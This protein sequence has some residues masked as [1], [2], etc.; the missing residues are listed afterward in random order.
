VFLPPVLRCP[1]LTLD[2]RRAP[3]RPL[4][5][6]HQEEKDDASRQERGRRLLHDVDGRDLDERG[7]EHHDRGQDAEVER[8]RLV[9]LRDLR[10]HGLAEADAGR[11][12]RAGDDREDRREGLRQEAPQEAPALR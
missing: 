10:Q 6:Q 5:E 11:D 4:E 12:P 1:T 7:R 8:G 9:Q 2:V 3:R